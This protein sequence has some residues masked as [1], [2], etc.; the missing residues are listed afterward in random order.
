MLKSK[1]HFPALQNENNGFHFPSILGSLVMRRDFRAMAGE[2][3][4]PGRLQR[5]D[6]SPDTRLRVGRKLHILPLTCS[7]EKGWKVSDR[8][9][10]PRG[11]CWGSLSCLWQGL[12]LAFSRVEHLAL[13]PAAALVT[14][15]SLHSSSQFSLP[16]AVC[17]LGSVPEAQGPLC[18]G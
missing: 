17:A 7:T 14:L 4:L 1:S 15:P 9:V 16:P 12:V 13:F 6:S 10:P 5:K 2:L 18:L 8:A 11:A 3:S